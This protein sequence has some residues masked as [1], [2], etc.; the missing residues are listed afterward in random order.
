MK[1][2][3]GVVAAAML[4]GC[5]LG[6]K[7]LDPL[8]DEMSPP[9]CSDSYRPVMG[10]MFLGGFGFGVAAAISDGSDTLGDEIAPIGLAVGLALL[11]DG[12]LADRAV[13]VCQDAQA[14]MRERA[15]LRQGP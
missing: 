5:S 10:D 1:A 4:C 3:A 14:R 11:V 15:R 7:R 13:R 8:W 2:I 9:D 12:L 6:M